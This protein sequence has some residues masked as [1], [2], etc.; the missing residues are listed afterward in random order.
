M[1]KTCD[2]RQVYYFFNLTF[3]LWS[4]ESLHHPGA[5]G[6][7]SVYA[8]RLQNCLCKQKILTFWLLKGNVLKRN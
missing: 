7:S 8:W 6:S 1:Y 5:G 2:R 3:S 4:I